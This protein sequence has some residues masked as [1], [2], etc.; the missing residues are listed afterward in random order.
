MSCI[1][2]SDQSTGSNSRCYP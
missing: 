2:L 1:F